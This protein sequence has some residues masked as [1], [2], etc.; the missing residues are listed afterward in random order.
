MND[1]QQQKNIIVSKFKESEQTDTVT[2]PFWTNMTLNTEERE[3]V[4]PGS[5]NPETLGDAIFKTFDEEGLPNSSQ[6]KA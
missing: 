2:S 6:L 5:N 4:E 3:K 1:K